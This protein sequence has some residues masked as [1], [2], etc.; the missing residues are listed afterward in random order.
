M[1]K[2][3]QNLP[4]KDANPS[5]SQY[6][7]CKNI[8]IRNFKKYYTRGILRTNWVYHQDD[9]IKIKETQDKSDK[10]LLEIK[11][12]NIIY[13]FYAKLTYNTD[14]S[15]WTRSTT[16]RL[17]IV[18]ENMTNKEILCDDKD[19]QQRFYL[20][21]HCPADTFTLKLILNSDSLYFN[22]NLEEDIPRDKCII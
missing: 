2:T 5:V 11:S 14:S 17:N 4:K 10:K 20:K 8:E 15:W 19:I 3:E 9:Y 1:S 18:F 7:I 13:I 16:D 21:K 12:N 22:T 6:G